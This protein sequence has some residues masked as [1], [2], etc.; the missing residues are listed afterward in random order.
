MCCDCPKTTQPNHKQKRSQTLAW[1]CCSYPVITAMQNPLQ[2]VAPD[3]PRPPN[4]PQQMRMSAHSCC[5]P[6]VWHK[7]E[8]CHAGHTKIS[9]RQ[10][11]PHTIPQ[12]QPGSLTRAAWLPAAWKPQ[13]GPWTEC[14][15]RVPQPQGSGR[16]TSPA[17]L[18]LLLQHLAQGPG[19]SPQSW[20]SVGL[21]CT[22]REH[23]QVAARHVAGCQGPRC[24]RDRSG[25]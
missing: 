16:G 9:E 4:L 14:R 20:A 2:E 19:R 6:C 17:V 1:C 12:S 22:H 15:E 24:R 18:H 23:V 13:K 21:P 11:R 7:G 3:T 10:C 8:P 5:T 25:S